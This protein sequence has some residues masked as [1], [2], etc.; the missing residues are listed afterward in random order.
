MQIRQA[1]QH[2]QTSLRGIA[3]RAKKMLL[4]EANDTEEPCAGKPHAGISEGAVG[5]LLSAIIIAAISGCL[6]FVIPY[7]LFLL[8]I[9]SSGENQ[10]LML[11]SIIIFFGTLILGGRLSGKIL[12]KANIEKKPF[13]KLIFAVPGLYIGFLGFIINLII[14]GRISTD[15]IISL[16][17]LAIVCFLLSAGSMYS[18]IN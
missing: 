1:D 15:G 3:K 4:Y 18:A 5:K 12:Q 2:M 14:D 6:V 10:F 13:Y 8:V 17:M 16:M 9:H 7:A 11:I